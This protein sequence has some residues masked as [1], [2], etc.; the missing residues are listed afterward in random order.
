MITN[1]AREGGGARW[2][3]GVKVQTDGYKIENERVVPS[4]EGQGEIQGLRS[5]R[6]KLLAVRQAARVCCTTWAT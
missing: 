1:G 3:R 2:G 4:A 5:E 6:Y